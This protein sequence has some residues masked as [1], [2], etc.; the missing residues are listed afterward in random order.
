[1]N[2]GIGSFKFVNNSNSD[3][4][5]IQPVFDDAY[6]TGALPDDYADLFTIEILNGYNEDGTDRMVI[7]H[8]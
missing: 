7:D 2:K 4:R 5:V 3:I 6:V 8:A 1:M